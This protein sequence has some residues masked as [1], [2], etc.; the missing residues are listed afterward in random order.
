MLHGVPAGAELSSREDMVR[1][2]LVLPGRARW[3]ARRQVGPPGN[4]GRG[5]QTQAVWLITDSAVE[6]G[7][8]RRVAVM[9]LRPVPGPV[10]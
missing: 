3:L 9:S 8:G 6:G 4:E 10:G 2:G 7:A 5:S 1:S